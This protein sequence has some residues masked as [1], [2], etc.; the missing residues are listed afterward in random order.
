[1][2]Q[3]NHLHLY[4]HIISI[5]M[6]ILFFF[7]VYKF[8]SKTIVFLLIIVLLIGVSFMVFK[9]HMT[10]KTFH[11]MNERAKK[12]KPENMIEILVLKESRYHTV[13]DVY[14]KNIVGIIKDE[15]DIKR[16]LKEY[17]K[18]NVDYKS[19]INI[20]ESLMNKEAD[21]IILSSMSSSLMADDKIDMASFRTIYS[22]KIV[23][24][25]DIKEKKVDHNKKTTSYEGDKVFNIYISGTDTYGSI[26]TVSRSDVNII[27]SVNMDTGKVLLIS[28]P[29]D[30]YVRI[31]GDGNNEYDKLTH[32]GVYGVE[33]SIET[34]ENLYDIDID[35]YV[36][37][38]FDSVIHII[39]LFDGVDVYNDQDFVSLHS[40]IH[41]KKGMVHLDSTNLLPF[42]R[43]RY[44]LVRGDH[45]RGRNQQK[46]I[47]AIIKK[48][49]KPNYLVSRGESIFVESSKYVETDIEFK[50]VMKWINY[51]VDSKTKFEVKNISV[52]GT[53]SI[54][55][56]SYAMPAHD[57]Y[58]FEIEESSLNDVKNQI[59]ELSLEKK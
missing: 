49:V 5:I 19:G 41:F 9:I 27:A 21:A 30:S 52:N 18:L 24:K 14:G 55:L 53:G 8:G 36:R 47:E 12:N 45:D 39:D 31:A 56:P 23:S 42:I 43:E 50:Q 58:M 6:S 2:F 22:E 16:T 13:E 4:I 25:S 33:S 34:L 46:V 28:T 44:S 51:V 17:S 38:N 32:A 10:M 48:I 35:Y 15:E 59:K 20:Y 40:S 37:L 57:L 7:L 1:M 54:G 3:F 11:D 29:R 26:D